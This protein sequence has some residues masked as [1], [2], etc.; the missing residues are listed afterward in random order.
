ME[1]DTAKVTFPTG[2]LGLHT[3]W[4]LEGVAPDRLN[5][6]ALI[7]EAMLRAARAC[8]ATVLGCKSHQF[9]PQG[10]TAL[11]L[12]AESHLAFHS[13][14]ERGSAAVDLFSCSPAMDPK[15]VRRVLDEV[16]AP[17]RLGE[18][19]FVRGGNFP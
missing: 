3:L 7:E 4:D 5:D 17:K 13:W 19:T 12:L 2:A 15:E 11:L 10:V 16:F 8:G 18:R 9:T 6:L 1:S 14:P